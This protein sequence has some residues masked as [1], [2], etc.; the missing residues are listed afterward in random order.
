MI[1]ALVGPWVG[2]QWVGELLG[3]WSEVGWSK[4]GR[5]VVNG[6]NKIPNGIMPS[7]IALN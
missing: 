6:F 4:I 2:G 5:S 1:V 3:K 7:E